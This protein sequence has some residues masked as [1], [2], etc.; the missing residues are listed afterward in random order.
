MV[1][2]KKAPKGVKNVLDK[3]G[4]TKVLP[5][6]APEPESAEF[7]VYAFAFGTAYLVGAADGELSDE[8]YNMLGQMM[9]DLLEV[10]LTAEQLDE[11]LENADAA[12]TEHGY[13]GAIEELAG[14]QSDPDL[15]R[16]AFTIAAAVGCA[17]GALDDA[18]TG[19]FTALADAYGIDEAEAQAIV[20]ECV[21]AYEAG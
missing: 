4:A 17:D 15:R 9:A 21:A 10:D 5:K 1:S 3:R 7:E 13:E 19:L 16:A 6:R 2:I 11:L 12:L 18:E 14:L 8:E 20:D